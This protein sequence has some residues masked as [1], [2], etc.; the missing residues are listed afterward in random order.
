VEGAVILKGLG[1]VA[2][3]VL[4]LWVGWNNWKHRDTVTI[5]WIEDKILAATDEEPLPRTRFD[6]ISRRI[7]AVLGLVF[8]LFFLAIGIGI[9]LT[10]V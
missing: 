6:G 4:L 7:Q 9:S 1:F 3:G 10:G 8:G 2:I 5:P